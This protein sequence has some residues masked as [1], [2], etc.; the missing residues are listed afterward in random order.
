M[1]NKSR[2]DVQTAINTNL[3]DNSAGDIT[4]ADTRG[5]QT[6]LNDS[7]L[8][9]IS[10]TA[11]VIIDG[12]AK[13]FMTPAERTKLTGIE[14]GADVTDAANVTAA[15][16]LM[17]SELASEAD[18]KALDQSVVSGASPNF[19]ISN[20]TLDAASLVV[21]PET[22]L[23]SFANGVDHSLL[24]VRGTGVNTSY[25]S[26]VSVGGTTLLRCY[27]RNAGRFS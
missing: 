19:T 23:Q 6:D 14:T 26:S 21:V 11:D 24:K 16:A 2:A 7:S 17:D 8:N 12:A 22:N 15:G 3:A 4:A 25:I 20:Q 13:V 27:R 18:V 9:I 1:A 10:D 5:T